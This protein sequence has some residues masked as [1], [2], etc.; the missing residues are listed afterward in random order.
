MI[1]QKVSGKTYDAFLAERAFKPSGMTATRRSSLEDIIP[2]RAAGYV[3]E[4]GKIRNSEYLNPTLWDNGDGGMLS[5]ALDLARWN[6]A[7][8]GDSLLSASSKQAM[9]TPVKLANGS[10][11]AYGF[12]WGVEEVNGHKRISHSGGRPGAATVI[13]RY[14][15]DKL[16]VIVLTNGGA[17]NPDTLAQGIA[18][19]YV[20]GLLPRQ[21]EAKVAANTLASYAGYYN[22]FGG[23]LKVTVD[24]GHLLFWMGDRLLD[25]FL[26]VSE[27]RF[28]SEEAHREFEIK[29]AASGAVTGMRLRM[30]TQEMQLERIGPLVQTLKGQIAGG[31]TANP[32]AETVLAALAQGQKLESQCVTKGLCKDIPGSLPELAGVQSFAFL[33]AQDCALGSIERHGS[34][35]NRVLYYKALRGQESKYVLVYLTAEG[36][37]TDFDFIEE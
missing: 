5:T 12:G 26:P 37:V 8:D 1:I 23:A 18:R 10:T 32:Q 30:G 25:E 3:W 24:K 21:K 13:A 34:K 27:T 35:V 4:H 17:A 2:G 11:Y 33:A 16:T 7:L 9:W 19:R 31:P 15:G 29:K 14:P 22:A 6:A 36:L 28:V 20:P